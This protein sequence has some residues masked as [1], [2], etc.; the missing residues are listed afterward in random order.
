MKDE[1]A[2]IGHAA[3]GKLF[4]R[5]QHS[6][7]GDDEI[8]KACDLVCQTLTK[9]MT[10]DENGVTVSFIGLDVGN[11]WRHF[12]DPEE[13]RRSVRDPKYERRAQVSPRTVA[14]ASFSQSEDRFLQAGK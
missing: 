2:N 1:L 8:A 9:H 4:S 12:E 11:A 6:H 13:F 3:L 5:V 10:E 14:D 7:T